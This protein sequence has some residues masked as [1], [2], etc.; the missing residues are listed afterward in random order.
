MSD[1]EDDVPEVI[2]L[3][4]VMAQMA[5]DPEM[6]EFIRDFA[7][8]ARQAMV[9]VE[10]GKYASFDDAMEAISG[11]RPEA[12]DLDELEDDEDE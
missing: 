2:M 4:E 7:A 1:F 5:A 6:A 12:I 8:M 3:P 11:N 10:S 9:D